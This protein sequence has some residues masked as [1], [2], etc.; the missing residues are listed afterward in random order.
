[1]ASPSP[2]DV[3]GASQG[4][5][6]GSTS[7]GPRPPNQ[8][9]PPPI[10]AAG[11]AS[12][13]SIHDNTNG[14]GKSPGMYVQRRSSGHDSMQS[15]RGQLNGHRYNTRGNAPQNA[16][17]NAPRGR[18]DDDSS[19]VSDLEVALDAAHDRTK[20]SLQASVRQLADLSAQIHMRIEAEMGALHSTGYAITR[21]LSKQ[22]HDVHGKLTGSE[23]KLHTAEQE[24]NARMRA[25][26]EMRVQWEATKAALEQERQ[27]RTRTETAL[28][29]AQKQHRAERERTDQLR[30]TAV[31]NLTEA[32]TA[33]LNEVKSTLAA[34]VTKAEAQTSAARDELAALTTKYDHDTAALQGELS[35]T[36]AQLH[37]VRASADRLQDDLK[38][39]LRKEAALT[40]QHADDI[41]KLKEEFSTSAQRM[42][43]ELA[44]AHDT[45][46]QDLRADHA[47][48]LSRARDLFN[49]A[50]TE[51]QLVQQ[52]LIET[53]TALTALQ[54]DLKKELR[55]HA[56]AEKRH[57]ADAA[58]IKTDHTQRLEAITKELSDAHAQ[59]M[60]A[61]QEG[62]V[63]RTAE[64]QAERAAD[65]QKWE[66]KLAA[67]E[68]QHKEREVAL[69]SEHR[70]DL[71]QHEKLLV[72]AKGESRALA[73][74]LRD[75]EA[76]RM[77]LQEEL[78]ELMRES[79]RREKSTTASLADMRQQLQDT[80]AENRRNVEKRIDSLH[81]DR[82]ADM[83]R[84]DDQH[85]A[86]LLDMMT[87]HD[88][89][90]R[91]LEHEKTATAGDHAR[92]L[93]RLQEALDAAQAQRHTERTR[94]T[95]AHRD[96][97]LAHTTAHT[98]EIETWRENVRVLQ[99]RLDAS[100]AVCQ[101]L[102]DDLREELR[103]KATTD[104]Q[105]G[106]EVARLKTELAKS[107][108][109]CTA[110]HKDVQHAEKMLQDARHKHGAIEADL[111]KQLA[112]AAAKHDALVAQK[113]AALH[114]LQERY[115]ELEQDKVLVERAQRLA[116]DDATKAN[117]EHQTH[118]QQLNAQLKEQQAD[119]QNAMD[120][121]RSEYE[122]ALEQ[123]VAENEALYAKAADLQSQVQRLQA[124]AAATSP[125]R[126]ASRAK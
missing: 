1:M 98:T 3:P 120:Q 86:Q 24:R 49:V 28:A 79:S 40:K 106:D 50:R 72:E 53:E 37:A 61:L 19:D 51:Q 88:A 23:H 111:R 84:S 99:S 75:N 52:K 80:E 117:A 125:R 38:E 123:Q 66:A 9:R 46:M 83:Q 7:V 34:D 68:T 35:T 67:L 13:P 121:Q 30:E 31:A 22:L 92:A 113:D 94:D 101:K 104:K 71:D 82:L 45:A 55:N 21:Q 58:A 116:A 15:P 105:L 63:Q 47:T 124:S 97:L 93:A 89:R 62:N 56:E 17:P 54:D 85:K 126:R 20:S 109:K 119:F 42:T 2:S 90:L 100:D 95:A 11:S 81:A 77:S 26:A 18:P 4:M 74:K 112:D 64:L 44:S 25:E 70:N 87:K 107:T 102:Q 48:A 114:A 16:R 5:P 115:R 110:M 32:H 76:S 8:Q 29:A 91:E 69:Q 103:S 78:K 59:R 12:L 27:H 118:K 96:A 43:T 122:T 36:R 60:Q 65:I 10:T 41:A 108:E 6:Q 14:G 57:A 39:H 33:A 73:D